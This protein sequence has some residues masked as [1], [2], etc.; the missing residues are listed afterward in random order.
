MT[1]EDIKSK[2]RIAKEAVN[3][4]DLE[5]R[6]SAFEIILNK[7]LEEGTVKEYVK[8]GKIKLEKKKP[9]ENNGLYILH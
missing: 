1:L 9:R 2:V 8:E 4:L 3:G 5:L 7:L 6:K